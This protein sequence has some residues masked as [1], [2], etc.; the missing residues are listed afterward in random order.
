MLA[1]IRKM[2]LKPR[3]EALVQ[4]F[5]SWDKPTALIFGS[6]DKYIKAA[7]TCDKFKSTCPGVKEVKLIDQCGHYPQEDYSQLV[8]ESLT[9]FLLS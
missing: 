8:N 2:R 6:N 4:K 5:R 9:A 3:V 1:T 7:A